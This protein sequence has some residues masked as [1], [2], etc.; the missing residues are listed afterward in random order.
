[1]KKL[2]VL[3]LLIAIVACSDKPKDEAKAA[4]KNI[5]VDKITDDMGCENCG[6][7]LKKF[8]STGHALKLDNGHAHFYCSINCSTIALADLEK[9]T[10]NV[11]AIDY[12]TTKYVDASTAHYVIGSEVR[13]TM[14]S[15]SKITF[16]SLEKAKK[17]SELYNGKQIVD[18]LTAKELS[19]SEI[20]KRNS[21]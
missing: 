15:L 4:I 17:F 5:S 16:A 21:H 9:S 19:T 3:I 7:N 10:K 1:M 11:F 18:Y 6:M 12:E 8:I 14:T 20:E 2:L 13:G